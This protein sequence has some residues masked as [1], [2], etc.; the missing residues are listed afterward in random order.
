MVF[1]REKDP[2]V[3]WSRRYPSPWRMT[4]HDR[5]ALGVAF[6]LAL[7]QGGTA[8]CSK[9][10]MRESQPC[11]WSSHSAHASPESVPDPL[12]LGLNKQQWGADLRGS[13]ISQGGLRM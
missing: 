4:S 2:V 8:I 3:S 7:L 11:V 1:P 6:A 9:S 10:K 5:R 13:R 12:P